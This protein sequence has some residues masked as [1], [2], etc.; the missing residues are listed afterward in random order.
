MEHIL[1]TRDRGK[2]YGNKLRSKVQR[3]R[4][5]K[6]GEKGK[7]QREGKNAVLTPSSKHSCARV[8]QSG[9][10]R[11]MYH[12]LPSP[13]PPNSHLCPY[14]QAVPR[15]KQRAPL[16]WSFSPSPSNAEQ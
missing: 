7:M 4:E 2:V 12:P 6:R 8:F 5:K 13:S 11:A 15:D 9:D 3:E 10:T 16:E 1:Y 14:E